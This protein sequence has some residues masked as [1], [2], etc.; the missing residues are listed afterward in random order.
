MQENGGTTNITANIIRKHSKSDEGKRLKI[1]MDEKKVKMADKKKQMKAK[2]DDR[3]KFK[4]S[5]I[6]TF[7]KTINIMQ[8]LFYLWVLA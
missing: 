4:Q 1:V 8:H 6:K 7:I 2:K 3:D 5:S